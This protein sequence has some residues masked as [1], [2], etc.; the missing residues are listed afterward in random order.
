MTALAGAGR[1]E[2]AARPHRRRAVARRRHGAHLQRRVRAG[3]DGAL[4]SL[5]H[6]V[7]GAVHPDDGRRRHARR[8]LHAAGAA[9]PRLEAAR[10]HLVVSRASC[11]RPRWSSPAGATSCTRASSIRSAASTRSGR[12]S[13]SATS[14]SPSVALCVG[15]TM[16]IKM[17]KARY[18]WVT[19]LPLAW[20]LTVTLTAGWQKVFAADPRLGFLA[21]AALTAQ[22]VAD[23]AMDPARGARLIFNDRLDAVV[24]IAFMLVTVLVVLASARE[25]VLVL[26]RRKPARRRRARSWRR[27]MR[28]RPASAAAGGVGAWSALVAAVRRDRR[29]A[30]LRRARRAPAPVPS[31]PAVA[32]RAGVLRGVRAGA[33]RRRA[34]A[35]LLRSWVILGSEGAMTQR[36]APSLRSG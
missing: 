15:T 7:R 22:Q 33:L 27:R 35:V 10:P 3:A 30:G 13:A 23:G 12:S 36:M 17:G 14:C 31:G 26:T 34:D 32:E 1:R 6:H 21:H 28:G 5:R 16:I 29:H 18:A 9:R 2:H 4:V 11:S 25:W 20:L 8:P 19:L 24:A